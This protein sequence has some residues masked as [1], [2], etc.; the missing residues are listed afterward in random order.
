MCKD[1]N[2]YWNGDHLAEKVRIA[3]FENITHKKIKIRVGN[4]GEGKT[5]STYDLLTEGKPSEQMYKAREFALST[6]SQCFSDFIYIMRDRHYPND[7]ERAKFTEAVKADLANPEY[8]LWTD[9]YASTN[10]YL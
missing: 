10:Y 2:I 7:L 9:M 1:M 5:P 4:W 8:K 3:G 6:W